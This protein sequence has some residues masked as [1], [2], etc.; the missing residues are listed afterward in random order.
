[1]KLLK[2]ILVTVFISIMFLGCSPKTS[3]IY[4]VAIKKD[5]GTII[6]YRPHN[7][8]WKNK[9]F[10]IYI[11]GKYEEMLMNR[12]H[13]LFYKNPGRYIIELREDIELEPESYKVEVQLNE[14]KVKYIKLGTNSIEDHL[15]LKSVRKAVAIG[16]EWSK[17][18]Y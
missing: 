12:S 11:N 17:K 5:K 6:V 10:N 14:G 1:M 3:S 18:R 13:H 16:D 8:I 9:R 2:L 15:K 7:S 4:N